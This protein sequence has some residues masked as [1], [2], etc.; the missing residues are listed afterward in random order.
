MRWSEIRLAARRGPAPAFEASPALDCGRSSIL[1]EFR[2]KTG[3][4][5]S[6]DPVAM[7]RIKDLAERTKIDLSA[8]EEAPFNIPFI[9][10]TAQGRTALQP[11]RPR[12]SA[13]L[14]RR[15]RFLTLT[16]AI[17][18]LWLGGV[19]VASDLRRRNLRRLPV[20][21]MSAR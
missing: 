15:L 8:R 7:Q 18:M 2:S 12:R 20:V 11:R 3:I 9:T 17:V 10:M 14:C 6:A 19:L 4:D 21:P 5:L 16:L 1:K 13:R